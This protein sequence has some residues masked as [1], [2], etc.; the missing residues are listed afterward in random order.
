MP[1]WKHDPEQVESVIKDITDEFGPISVLVNNA[2][3]TEDN[4]L[5]RMKP[6][7]WERTLTRIS[8][9]SLLNSSALK[10]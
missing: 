10:A 6:S 8:P 5:M 7:Q 2:G 1:Y 9:L 3:V 4:P